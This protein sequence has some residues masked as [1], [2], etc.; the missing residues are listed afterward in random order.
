MKD[1]RARRDDIYLS[2]SLNQQ[3]I[4]PIDRFSIYTISNHQF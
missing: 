2:L 4:E 1:E 3:N